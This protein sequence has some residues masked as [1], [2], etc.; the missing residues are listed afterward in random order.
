MRESKCERVFNIQ[1]PDWV[2]WG[3]SPG[4]LI[5]H[6]SGCVCGG[7]SLFESFFV[8]FDSWWEQHPLT[9]VFLTSLTRGRLFVL[10]TNPLRGPWNWFVD[11]DCSGDLSLGQCIGDEEVLMGRRFWVGCGW[12]FLGGRGGKR[13]R[14]VTFRR[15]S[16]RWTTRVVKQ[17]YFFMLY[18]IYWAVGVSLLHAPDHC[19]R[20]LQTSSLWSD[21]YDVEVSI[22]W[23]PPSHT[24]DNVG[25]SCTSFHPR[26]SIKLFWGYW[27]IW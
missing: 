21:T 24:E 13:Q 18:I 10:D 19:E 25:T 7:E 4:P 20:R 3:D 8:G 2:E 17:S 15:V 5:G 23:R 22:T 12:F 26:F 11:G 27:L 14:Q 16:F 6:T 1:A 9:S